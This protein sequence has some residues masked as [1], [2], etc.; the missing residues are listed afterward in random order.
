MRTSKFTPEQMVA[1][2][3]QGESGVPVVEVCRQHGISEQTYYRWKKQL[4]DISSAELKEL[5]QLRDENRKLK[6]LVADLT[7]DKTI[8]REA[9]TKKSDADPVAGPGRLGRAQLSAHPAPGLRGAR[10]RALE[11]PVHRSPAAAGRLTSP[12]PGVGRGPGELRVSA[13]DDSVTAR[14]VA[15]E[16]EAGVSA[17]S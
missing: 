1:I 8:L 4:G 2:C 17:L 6:T 13:A 3:R 12:P 16:C 14:G 11:R 5:R 10:G 15:R 9:L 7:L